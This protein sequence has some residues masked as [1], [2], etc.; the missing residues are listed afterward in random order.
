MNFQSEYTRESYTIT[1]MRDTFLDGH[2]CN[3]GRPH[4]CYENYFVYFMNS[5]YFVYSMDSSPVVYVVH[6]SVR[7]SVVRPSVVRNFLVSTGKMTAC[8]RIYETE[9][10]DVNL[11]SNFFEF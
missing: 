9:T 11:C 4:F 10:R 6:P 1:P 7:P 5:S 8:I 3:R 2:H